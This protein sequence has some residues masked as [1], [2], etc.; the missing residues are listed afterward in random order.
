MDEYRKTSYFNAAMPLLDHNAR[1]YFTQWVLTHP[2]PDIRNIHLNFRSDNLRRP[3]A[4]FFNT[5]RVRRA[6]L[7]DK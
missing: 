1:L 7:E 6:L 5:E 3:G 2:D 4:K